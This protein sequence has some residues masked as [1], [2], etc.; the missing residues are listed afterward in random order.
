MRS[1]K[2]D[3]KI[4]AYKARPLLPVILLIIAAALLITAA[5]LFLSI[6]APPEDLPSTYPDVDYSINPPLILMCAD[7]RRSPDYPWTLCSTAEWPYVSNNLDL[8]KL[9]IGDF[10]AETDPEAV[11][12]FAEAM[13]EK[14]IKIALEIGGLLDW[15]AD[16]DELSALYSFKEEYEQVRPFILYVKEKSGIDLFDLIELDCPVR[17]MLF[18]FDQKS[19]YH[20]TSTAV[21]ELVKVIRYWRDVL[22]DAQINMIT[23][24]PVWGWK[25][26]PAYVSVDGQ[27]DGYGQYDQVLYEIMH[28]TDLA[29]EGLDGLTIDNPYDYAVSLMPSNQTEFI[30]GIDWVG[31]M[32]DLEDTAR[33]YGLPVNIIFNSETG[34][35]SSNRIFYEHTL[36]FITQYIERGGD[37]DGFWIQSWY[38]HPDRWLSEDELYTLTNLVKEVILTVGERETQN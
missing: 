35:N 32:L 9:Y 6:N 20:S 13:N 28:Q 15:H 22:P 2:H 30:E 11:R 19:S 16:K 23:N 37:P 8:I 34:G 31:R 12:C 1:G 4:N 25:G 26:L 10:N 3:K 38:P 24:F 5:V 33:N 14:E 17:R 29:G 18:P 27:T 36:E 7:G 21:G